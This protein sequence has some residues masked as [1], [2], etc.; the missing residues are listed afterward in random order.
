MK[1]FSQ[2]LVFILFVFTFTAWS[3]VK[4]PQWIPAN[5]RAKAN[6]SGTFKTSDGRKIS[7]KELKSKVIFLNFWATWCTPCREEMPSMARLHEQ[8]RRLI[9]RNGIE[10]A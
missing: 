5:K 10:M 2:V 3:E 4:E 6:L 9:A 8:L 7:L 1:R